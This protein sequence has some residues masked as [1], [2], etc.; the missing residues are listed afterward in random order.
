MFS[1][2]QNAVFTS[3]PIIRMLD[4]IFARAILEFMTAVIV[5]ALTVLMLSVG[6]INCWP[7]NTPQAVYA[8]GASV[9]LAFGTGMFNAS[10]ATIFPQWVTVYT[11][12]IIVSYAASGILFV[13]SNLP[14]EYRA[15]L[16]YSP[17]L[18]LVEWMRSAY[19]VNYPKLVLD[20]GYI[21]EFGFFSAGLGLLL[22][23]M[24]RSFRRN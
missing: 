19:Y 3:Y 13:P 16:S 21:L 1:V 10:I 2:P 24:L 6:G 17:L 14:E 7:A 4:V 23:M 22:E 5:V 8:L 9:L 20:R 18:Q 15:I 11:L 12:F